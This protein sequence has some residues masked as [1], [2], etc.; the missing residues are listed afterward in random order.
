MHQA[1][2]W[3]EAGADESDAR[4]E[5]MIMMMKTCT[6]TMRLRT[7][8][9][10]VNGFWKFSS[11]LEAMQE[12]A[13][14]HCSAL[15]LG[16]NELAEKGL[17]WVLVRNEV[18][19]SRYP[20]FGET[21]SVTTFPKAVRHRFFPRYFIVRDGQ[22][23]TI[24][25]AA[26]LW[27]LFD[28][29]TRQAVDPAGADIQL[30]DNSDLEAP[31][32]FPGRIQECDG[33]SRTIDYAV[34]YTDLDMT[35]HVNNARYADWFCNALGADVMRKERISSMILNYNAE[36]RE[37]QTV[38]LALTRQGGRAAMT[39]TAGDRNAFEIGCAFQ[40]A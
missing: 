11:I 30:P 14:D 25:M 33:E 32:P 23:E 19:I 40:D 34:Q 20:G 26:S 8:D 9:C 3:Q 2:P 28:L 18:R 6:D 4:R 15:R 29:H 39:G 13:E 1:R 17:S 7:K 36:I 5:K 37:G 22:G 16:R 38:R 12:T 10:D 35:A 27:V 31:M 21:V 24:G